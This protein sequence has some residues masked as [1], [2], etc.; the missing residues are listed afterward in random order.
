MRLIHFVTLLAQSGA[1]AP[2][3]PTALAAAYTSATQIDLSWTPGAG[4][5]SQNIYRSDD[6]GAY[7]LVDTIADG[8]TA[9]YED[10]TVVAAHIYGYKVAA[11]NAGGETL[12]AEVAPVTADFVCTTTAP[13]QT[14]TLD[15]FGVS[16]STIVDWGDGSTNAYTGTAQRTHVYA[17]ASVYD[18]RILQPTQVVTLDLRDTKMSS[19]SGFIGGLTSLTVLWLLNSAGVTVGAGEIGGLTSLTSLGMLNSTGIA[20]QTGLESLLQLD[21]LRYENNLSQAQVDSVLLTQLYAAFSTRTATNGT[22]DLLGVGNAAPSGVLQAACPPTTGKEA[23]FE[24]VN[25][26][27]GTSANHWASV[28]TAA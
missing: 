1:A 19:A 20:F 23:A 2:E 26:S 7:A 4:S 8:V 3:A 6:G 25:D 15:S 14:L 28:T 24:L 22:V 17:S 18:V 11:A 27:C 16:A 5:T 9:T 10:T 21:T 13:S 12:S